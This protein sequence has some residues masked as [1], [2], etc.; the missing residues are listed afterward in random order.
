MNE[1]ERKNERFFCFARTPDSQKVRPPPRS[2]R[3]IRQ[4][5]KKYVHASSRRICTF[6]AFPVFPANH[7]MLRL[8]WWCS[9]AQFTT[10]FAPCLQSGVW[11]LHTRLWNSVAGAVKDEVV[12]PDLFNCIHYLTHDSNNFSFDLGLQLNPT[13]KRNTSRT[14]T[15]V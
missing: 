15:L 5:D 14:N 7:Y 11:Q 3:N 10:Y 2:L 6:R 8:N 13:R 4:Y 9:E 1:V 12:L